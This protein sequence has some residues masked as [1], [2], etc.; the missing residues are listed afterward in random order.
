M[1]CSDEVGIA[2]D[3]GPDEPVPPPQPAMISANE[4]NDNRGRSSRM[5]MPAGD[6]RLLLESIV[7]EGC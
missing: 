3:A 1:C 5:P 2:A 6:R 7:I 4:H